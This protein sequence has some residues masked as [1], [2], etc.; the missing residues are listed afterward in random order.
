VT[1]NLLDF[2]LIEFFNW[3]L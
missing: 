2:A 1:G 3:L